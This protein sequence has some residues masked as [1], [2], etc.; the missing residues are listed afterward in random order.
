MAEDHI[1]LQPVLFPLQ[2]IDHAGGHVV[3][4]TFEAHGPIGIA[5][6]LESFHQGGCA[7]NAQF[8]SLGFGIFYQS[9]YVY[10]SYVFTLPRMIRSFLTV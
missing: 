3:S 10:I 4:V 1:L 2:E 9:I 8:E 5:L 6:L 7:E